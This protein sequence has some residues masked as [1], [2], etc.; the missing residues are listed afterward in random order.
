MEDGKTQSVS[1]QVEG[2]P[3]GWTLARVGRVR[4]GE[5]FI[6]TRGEVVQ[7]AGDMVSVVPIV[8]RLPEPKPVCTWPG[9]PGYV[10][11]VGWLARDPDGAIW[12]FQNKPVPAPP[13]AGKYWK[14]GPGSDIAYSRRI[15]SMGIED[16]PVFNPDLAWT[17]HIVEVGGEETVV[18]KDEWNGTTM[19]IQGKMCHPMVVDND[20]P[21]IAENEH[22]KD[23]WVAQ[24]DDGG[25]WWYEERPKTGNSSYLMWVESPTG[26]KHLPLSDNEVVFPPSWPWKKRIVRIVGNKIVRDE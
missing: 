2:V 7:A 23:G 9:R 25:L 17:E 5:W 24:D 1:P 22:I 18:V 14:S 13:V 10:K 15:D 8:E 19:E 4:A 16:L 3:E 6:G 11:L 21:R 12:L 26:S 20:V